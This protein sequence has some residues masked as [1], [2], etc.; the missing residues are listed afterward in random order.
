MIGD[1]RRGQGAFVSIDRIRKGGAE[2]T[3]VSGKRDRRLM[4]HTKKPRRP[5]RGEVRESGAR[6]QTRREID[7]AMIRSVEV[8][9]QAT[10]LLKSIT[11]VQSPT[12]RG[13]ADCSKADCLDAV[14]A[15]FVAPLRHTDCIEQC[16]LS[17]GNPDCG[18]RA[19]NRGRKIFPITMSGAES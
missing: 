2:S 9:H 13:N 3:P 14:A 5:R 12:A 18:Q 11:S 7:C 16:P 8:A 6:S 4:Q 1:D 10:C 15:F 17:A 19:K